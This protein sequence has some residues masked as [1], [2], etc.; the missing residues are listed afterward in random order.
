[1]IVK[2]PLGGTI[3]VYSHIDVHFDELSDTVQHLSLGKLTTNTS[4]FVQCLL[5]EILLHRIISLLDK[6]CF[7]LKI[8]N[9]ILFTVLVKN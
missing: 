8:A 1:M 2:F 4:T 3:H 6:K 9:D 7:N 5:K